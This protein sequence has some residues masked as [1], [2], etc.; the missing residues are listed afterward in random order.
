MSSGAFVRS[1][2]SKLR[3]PNSPA[4]GFPLLSGFLDYPYRIVQVAYT[5]VI[6]N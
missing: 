2:G 3:P 1:I 4:I 6:G 5:N